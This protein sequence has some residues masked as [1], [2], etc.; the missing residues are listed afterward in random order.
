MHVQN[1]AHG[2]FF[3]TFADVPLRTQYSVNYMIKAIFFDIDGTLVS[4][5]TH[6][7]PVAT[8]RALE[9]LRSRG[10]KLF[11]A[12]GRHE[13]LIGN[14]VD[15]GMFDG[16]VSLNGQCVRADGKIIHA[17]AMPAEDARAAAKFCLEHGVT[18]IFENVS[19]LHVNAVTPRALEGAALI[20][21]R[22]P[23]PSDIMAAT[24][25][26][27]LQLIFFGDTE[28]ESELL[29]HM[30]SCD[31]TRWTHL[32]CDVIPRGGGKHVG[33]RQMLNYYG[34]DRDECMAF[35]DGEND[36]SMLQYV[37]TGIAM[38]NASLEVKA[39]ADYVT[40]GI[41]SGGL[42]KALNKFGLL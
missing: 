23:E 19:A 40:T 4:F 7:V 21:M 20:N 17:N 37:G 33:I 36:I 29:K 18:T 31:A 28:Q 15:T 3:S 9:S 2:K 39:A 32:L 42:V 10:V 6:M 24:E 26:P 27:V 34:I 25:E 30:P 1:S 8:L 22:F 12:T 41:D 38:G 16:V 5:K 14:A 11:I 13:L 35:G